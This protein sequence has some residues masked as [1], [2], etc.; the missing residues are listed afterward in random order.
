V[1]FFSKKKKVYTNAVCSGPS[2]HACNCPNNCSHKVNS[3]CKYRGGPSGNS[4][5]L[6][7]STQSAWFNPHGSVANNGQNVSVSTALSPA[8]PSRARNRR[9]GDMFC[10]VAPWFPRVLPLVENCP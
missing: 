6:S 2:D 1:T 9:L 7:G 10:D 8:L 5:V 3:S 4:P